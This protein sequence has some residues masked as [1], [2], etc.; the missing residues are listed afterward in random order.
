M[1]INSQQ[2]R[3]QNFV[4]AKTLCLVV[5]LLLAIFA[6][7]FHHHATQADSDDCPLCHAVAETAVVDL[8]PE[9]STPLFIAAGFVSLP[10]L[11]RGVRV[12]SVLTRIPRGPPLPAHLA[13]FREGWTGAA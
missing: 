12:F 1:L 10:P 8:V 11:D 3:V 9:L 5:L 7:L 4:Q 13:I 6:F 2:V